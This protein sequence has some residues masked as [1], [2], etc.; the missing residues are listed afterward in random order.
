MI[1]RTIKS[2]KSNSRYIHYFK[3]NK[4]KYIE[5]ELEYTFK[6]EKL[7]LTGKE[8]QIFG[9]LKKVAEKNE[10]KTVMRVAGGWVRDKVSSS[11]MVS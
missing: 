1:S 9:L 8:E 11:L 4:F 7:S 10:L 2:L 6:S 3:Y 5:M